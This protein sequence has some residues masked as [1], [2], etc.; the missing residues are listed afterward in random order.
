MKVF[1]PIRTAMSSP[2]P[3]AK[4]S[5]PMVPVKEMLTRSPFAAFSPSAFGD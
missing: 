1:E 2:L 5:P 3:P 4:G